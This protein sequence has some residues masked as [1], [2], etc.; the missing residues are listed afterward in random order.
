MLPKGSDPQG[1]QKSVL[2]TLT[3]SNHF[4]FP[5]TLSELSARLIQS[6][7]TKIKLAKAISDLVAQKK[8]E[9]RGDY[10]YLPGRMLLISR[11]EQNKHTSLPVFSKAKHLATK[12]SKVSGVLAIYL[13]GSLAMSNSTLDSDIDFMIITNDNR[14]WTT[15]FL[16]TLYTTLLGLRRT[17][18]SKSYASKLCL[19]LYLSPAAYLLP[20]QKRSL[21]T[22]YELIQAVPLF[23]PTDTHSKLLS[24]NAWI[25][26]YLPNFSLPKHPSPVPP[27]YRNTGV[28]EYFLYHLQLF[29]M[30]RKITREY[31]TRDS[32]FFHPHNPAP[33]VY[34]PNYVSHD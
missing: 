5:L 16:L 24:A 2:A 23:D 3:Y 26:D 32:A 21:Y 4:G 11:R 17:P 31:I 6:S 1:I 7:C 33:K 27:E 12:L 30:K 29:Y 10:Y 14:L 15:R 8:I 34:N 22:A 25:Q 28:L 20:P 19:N 18:H 9:K 13:T